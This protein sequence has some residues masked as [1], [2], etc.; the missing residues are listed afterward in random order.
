MDLDAFDPQGFLARVWLSNGSGRSWTLQALIE[1]CA[2]IPGMTQPSE[3]L[4]PSSRLGADV[5]FRR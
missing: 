3:G 4:G 1:P 5:F 2:W